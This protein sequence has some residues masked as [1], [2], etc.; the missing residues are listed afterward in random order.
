MEPCPLLHFFEPLLEII[1]SPSPRRS[2]CFGPLLHLLHALDPVLLSHPDSELNLVF[3]PVFLQ[4][5]TLQGF[6]LLSTPFLSLF[7]E[8][9]VNLLLILRHL[10]LS[11]LLFALQSLHKLSAVFLSLFV[12][13]HCLVHRLHKGKWYF[14]AVLHRRRGP[15]EVFYLARASRLLTEVSS[16]ADFRL[17]LTFQLSPRSFLTLL[18]GTKFVKDFIARFNL[19]TRKQLFDFFALLTEF[20][21]LL[22]PCKTA[23]TLRSTS[24]LLGP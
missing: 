5:L 20:L 1:L 9:C 8:L 13:R 21:N 23:V 6:V 14:D 15:C 17:V 4:L 3:P 19:F 22:Q 2:D 11:L 7:I 10:F 18:K 24:C 12:I 16:S